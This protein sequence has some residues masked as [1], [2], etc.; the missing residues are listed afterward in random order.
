[1]SSTMTDEQFYAAFKRWYI[2]LLK[3]FC[4]IILCI[5]LKFS[6]RIFVVDTFAIP[7]E[8]MYPTIIPGDK[9]MVNKLV[10]GARLYDD[11]D[12]AIHS[13]RPAVTRVASWSDIE[14]GDLAVFNFPFPHSYSKI[15]FNISLV[16]CKRCVALPGDTIGAVNGFLKNSACHDTLGHIPSQRELSMC[17]DSIMDKGRGWRTYG[18]DSVYRRWTIKNFGPLY[19]PKKGTTIGLDTINYK[20]YVKPI[21]Y[22]TQLKLEMRDGQLTLGGEPIC[23]YTF[24]EDYYFFVGDNV[25]SS[26]DS[27]YWGFVPRG[28]IV[29]VATHI[30]YSKSRQNGDM[31][32][33]RTLKRI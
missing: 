3:V 24:A 30:F 29:G 25:L 23:N 33:S 2:F 26:H 32:W 17:V 14:R 16:Y 21:E 1:M 9:V 12:S 15:E 31:R 13:R 20:L 27:R 4:V 8:S 6:L 22:E 18:Y 5:A 28:H 10:M 19:V 7:T 11:L